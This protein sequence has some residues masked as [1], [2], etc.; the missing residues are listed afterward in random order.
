MIIFYTLTGNNS[1]PSRQIP[2]KNT[3]LS[4][5]CCSVVGGGS[6]LPSFSSKTVCTQR[7]DACLAITIPFLYWS[8][9]IPLGALAVLKLYCLYNSEQQESWNFPRLHKCNSRVRDNHSVG[10]NNPLVVAL[11]SSIFS[12]AYTVRGAFENQ[13]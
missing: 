10:L 4:S 13:S 3:L 9:F 7:C 12:L 5:K 2:A 1:R 11:A 6:G 8:H